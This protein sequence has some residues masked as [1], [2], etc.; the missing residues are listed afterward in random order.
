MGPPGGELVFR[1]GWLPL[2]T[3]ALD[4]A[5]TAAEHS[6]DSLLQQRALLLSYRGRL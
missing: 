1:F 5:E 4:R 6:D 2:A 3:Q